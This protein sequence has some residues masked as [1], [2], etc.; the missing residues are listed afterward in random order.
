M[1]L[2]EWTLCCRG[3]GSYRHNVCN[4]KSGSIISKD[5]NTSSLKDENYIVMSV[6]PSGNNTTAF[7][8][9]ELIGI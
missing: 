8:M 7:S 9:N 4:N 1:T 6:V 2:K 5:V 3:V